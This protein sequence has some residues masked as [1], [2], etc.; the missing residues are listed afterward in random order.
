M[1]FAKTGS[2]YME[3]YVEDR[4]TSFHNTSEQS[5]KNY[6]QKTIAFLIACVV[7]DKWVVF[8]IYS[9]FPPSIKLTA[10]M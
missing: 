7:Y 9:G 1:A 6:R 10:M 4:L 2:N 3:S 5:V 8:R